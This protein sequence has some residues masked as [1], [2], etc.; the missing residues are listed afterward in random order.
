MILLEYHYFAIPN[1]LVALDVEY[2]W[3]LTSKERY[4]GIYFLMEEYI[5]TYEVD[6]GGKI[7]S[8][9]KRQNNFFEDTKHQNQIQ[10]WQIY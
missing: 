10:I 8:Y 6:S 3:L 7:T 4:T 9:T 2:Q 5:T 1:E